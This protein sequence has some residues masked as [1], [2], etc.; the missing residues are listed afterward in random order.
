MSTFYYFDYSYF[1]FMLPAILLAAWAQIYVKSSFNKY[2]KVPTIRRITGAQAAEA[3]A[4]YG[5]AS[6]FI[7][8]I[9]GSLTDNFDPRNHTI[10]LSQDVYG[11]ISVAAVGVAAHEAG[12]A[13]QDAMGY[14]PNKIRAALVPVTNLGSQ[15][16]IP[17]IIIGLILP[18]RFDFLVY[19]GIILYALVVLFELATLPVEFNASHRAIKTLDESGILTSE[20]LNGAKTVLKA[21][22]MTYVAASFTALLT[23]LRF[24]MI[25]NSRR[26]DN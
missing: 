5:G 9:T 13:V 26:G 16:S 4:H 15:L 6:V 24:L 12:H 3:V 7:Q 21:A 22:A 23:L 25:A 2:S 18:T 19:A 14:T 20:E 11:S 10:S 8:R 17:L 1:L